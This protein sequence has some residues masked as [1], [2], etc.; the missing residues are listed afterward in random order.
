MSFEDEQR[1]LHELLTM[2]NQY[3]ARGRHDQADQLMD[4]VI[5]I[6]ARL[7]ASNADPQVRKLL[8]LE[9]AGD[10]EPEDRRA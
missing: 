2:A 3:R 9:D 10:K 7:S 1:M 4:L 5:S 8:H 6:R